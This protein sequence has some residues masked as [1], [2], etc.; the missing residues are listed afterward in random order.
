MANVALMAN[1][2]FYPTRYSF[3]EQCTSNVNRD[4]PIFRQHFEARGIIDNMFDQ[5]QGLKC[6][7]KWDLDRHELARQYPEEDVGNR[8][9][10]LKFIKE[11]GHSI[12][13]IITAMTI[14]TVNMMLGR[15]ERDSQDVDIPMNSKDVARH[16]DFLYTIVNRNE[17]RAHNAT[18]EREEIQEIQRGEAP[19]RKRST[20]NAVADEDYEPGQT[21]QRAR[22]SASATPRRGTQKPKP[23]GP[24]PLPQPVDTPERAV[25]E[26]LLDD[27]IMN[28]EVQIALPFDPEIPIGVSPSVQQSF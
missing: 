2:T 6:S 15:A 9:S 16:E 25:G 10:Y 19:K 28:P 20:R 17:L 24:I 18:F 21:R 8:V 26:V 27:A 22:G 4:N 3:I 13:L 23:Q 5:T 12:Y 14:R 11:K 1:L 7:G